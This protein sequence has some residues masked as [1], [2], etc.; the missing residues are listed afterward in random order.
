M[1]PWDLLLPSPSTDRPL[2]MKT[3]LFLLSTLFPLFAAWSAPAKEKVLLI[4]SKD[5][6]PAWEGYMDWKK[7]GG[8]AVSLM[9]I[10]QIA[11]QYKGSDIQEKIRL[12]VRD[13]IKNHQA[14][15]VVL[16][17][18]SLP[19]GKG[20]V[21]DRDTVHKNMWG[22][23]EDL[24]TDIY[25]LSP[26]NWDADGDGIYG[27]FSDD[28]EA[29]TYP[30]GKVG[31]GRIPVRTAVDVKA[32]TEKV[33]SYESKYPKGE[34]GRNMTYTCEVQGAYAKVRRSWDD[35]VS[36]VLKGGKMSRYF[37]DETPWDGDQPGDYQL[38]PANWIKM[39]NAKDTGKMHFHGHGLLHCW[40]LENHQ[41][42]TAKHVAQ[43]TNKDAYPVI[44]TVSCFTGHFDSAKDPCIT[45]SMLRAPG[46]GAIAVVAPC[47]E[48]KPHFVDPRKSMRLMVREGKMDGTTTTMTLFWEKGIGDKLT[49]GEAL[50]QTKAA[51]AAKAGESANFH[52]CL[53]E[54][55]L[56][57]DP[58]IRVHPL[59]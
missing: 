11:I 25:Y 9:T 55:N 53:S 10:E 46:A 16:G 17:G 52:M 54:L 39:I 37:S 14:R 18:D 50:M 4:T 41:V 56:L 49:T 31:L 19:G 38:S 26:T 1:D 30:D 3:L 21:P 27:E 22:L 43:L 57:G 20:V 7:E 45:E 44:T 12:C 47:R 33:I 8:K 59:D 32:Y 34:F 42:F 24:P 28:R 5:L 6:A 29:I 13:F 35:H 23:V 51:L 58:T 36:K 48:G 2:L 40:V 15:W